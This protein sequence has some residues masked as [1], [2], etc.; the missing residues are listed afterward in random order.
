MGA[1][2]IIGKISNQERNEHVLAKA[3]WMPL[4]Y[5]CNRRLAIFIHRCYHE[6]I[7]Q[8]MGSMFRRDMNTRISR[9]DFKI[10][11]PNKEIG[12]NT[13]KFRGPGVWKNL[14][15]E[16]KSCNSEEVFKTK[17]RKYKE[18]IAEITYE[19]GALLNQNKD[20][21]YSFMPI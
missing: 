21:D 14:P 5:M 11:R 20:R 4:R 1:A 8:R 9:D 16:V 15:Q 19:K 3:G 13:V 12:R 10:M 2:R 18:Q 7:D 17:I 6:K